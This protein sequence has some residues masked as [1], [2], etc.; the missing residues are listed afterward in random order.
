MHTA[1]S[2]SGAGARQEL[3]CISTRLNAA[4]TM[5]A[6]LGNVCCRVYS[7][8]GRKLI[9]WG[10]PCLEKRSDE[11]SSRRSISACEDGRSLVRFRGTVVAHPRL[12]RPPRQSQ[13]RRR[14][15]AGVRPGEN[16]RCR[17]APALPRGSARKED[18]RAGC[19]CHSPPSRRFRIQMLLEVPP[20]VGGRGLHDG[21][22]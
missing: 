12:R 18:A 6:S 1:S 15:I 9:V 10:M 19:Q 13:P 14:T 8:Q 20:C 21:F 5:L 11:P 7:K 22:G 4:M 16:T 17:R 3:T 2:T